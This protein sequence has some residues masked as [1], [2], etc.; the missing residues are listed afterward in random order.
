MGRSP[1][2]S[3]EEV[4]MSAPDGTPIRPRGAQSRYGAE[5]RMANGGVPW[6]SGSRACGLPTACT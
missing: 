3:P 5:N 4:T 1:I 2:C 6:M